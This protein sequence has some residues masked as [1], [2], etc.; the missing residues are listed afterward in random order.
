MATDVIE[1]AVSQYEANALPGR[2]MDGCNATSSR[3]YFQARDISVELRQMGNVQQ[4]NLSKTN[5]YFCHNN[6]NS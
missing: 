5:Q 1:L 2:P 3:G 6:V 4:H